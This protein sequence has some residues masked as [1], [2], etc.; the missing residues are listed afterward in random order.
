MCFLTATGLCLGLASCQFRWPPGN[1]ADQSLDLKLLGKWQQIGEDDADPATWE[2]SE[3]GKSKFRAVFKEGN[4]QMTFEVTP[5]QVEGRQA[6]QFY[7]TDLVSDGKNEMDQWK[8]KTR[9]ALVRVELQYNAARASYLEPPEGEQFG[10][11]EEQQKWIA[12]AFG[13]SKF[14]NGKNYKRVP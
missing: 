1:P 10:T 2:V 5:V 12:E 9:Y 3:A 4:D 6:L 7:L 8:D 13:Q 11:V 14:W